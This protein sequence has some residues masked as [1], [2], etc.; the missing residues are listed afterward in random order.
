M[1]PR[2]LL[3]VLLTLDL[4]SQLLTKK[5]KTPLP[6]MYF[7]Y[8]IQ[9]QQNRKLLLDT[10]L[11]PFIVF[12]LNCHSNILRLMCLKSNGDVTVFLSKEKITW[13]IYWDSFKL[14]SVW[15]STASW[16]KP[17]SQMHSK[18]QRRSIAI[19]FL[20]WSSNLNYYVLLFENRTSTK[21]YSY[22]LVEYLESLL[23]Q[24]SST[25]AQLLNIFIFIQ[26]YHFYTHLHHTHATIQTH[27]WLY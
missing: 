16:I 24:T 4:F 9:K 19:A 6:H 3:S 7:Q 12:T 23:F 14:W 26:T 11:A 17:N 5:T 21:T 27:G 15:W 10:I 20:S 25:W 13:G 22:L 8:W 1:L 2:I 18:M